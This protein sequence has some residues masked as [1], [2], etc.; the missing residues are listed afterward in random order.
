MPVCLWSFDVDDSRR[1]EGKVA[2]R[3]PFDEIRAGDIILLH[4]DNPIC[5]AEL[6][7]LLEILRRRDLRPARV[8]TLLGYEGR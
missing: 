2:E 7:R 4:D 1:H 5:V 8:S 6:P 3:R